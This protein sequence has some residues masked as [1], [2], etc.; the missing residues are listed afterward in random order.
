M[1]RMLRR[2]WYHLTSPVFGIVRNPTDLGLYCGW[3]VFWVDWGERPL[4]G[5]RISFSW[6]VD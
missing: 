5:R 3:F 6:D 4:I 1:R 2:L